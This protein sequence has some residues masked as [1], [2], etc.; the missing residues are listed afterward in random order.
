MPNPQVF[1]DVEIGGSAAGR[2]VFELRADVAP[3]TAENFRLLCTGEKGTG[4][5][6]KTL[7]YKG[8]IFHR[9]IPNFMCQGGD[10][11]SGDG[12]GGES[13]YGR[14]FEDENFTLKHDGPGVLS[15]ANA[16][17][18]TNGSQFFLCTVACPWLDGKHV[19]FGRLIE[20][21]GVMKR[22]EACGSRSGKT[23]KP[24]VI[25]DCGQISNNLEYIRKLQEERKELEALRQD[26]I[27]LDA[28]KGSLTR[29]Q[30][31]RE[32]A[33]KKQEASRWKFRAKT[34]QDE[35]LELDSQAT[36]TSLAATDGASCPPSSSD[37]GN[38]DDAEENGG[39][40]ATV[41][42]VDPDNIEGANPLAGLSGR[43]RK[44][45]ELRSR[46]QECR[47][48]NQHAVIAETKRRQVPN[49]ENSVSK[50]KWFEERKKR[51]AAELERLGLPPDAVHRIESA[52]V[53]QAKH[54]KQKEKPTPFG[55][56][57]FNQKTLYKAYEKRA[58]QVP[59]TLEDYEEEKKRNPD[60]YG[61]ASGLEYGRTPDVPEEN[62]DKMVGELNEAQRRRQ[63]F[64]RRRRH[65]EDKDIDYINDRN[66][67]F[68]KKIERAFGKFTQEIRAN[69]ERGTALPD[70]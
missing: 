66:A 1:F 11:T 49:A 32:Q 61:D 23:L 33:E 16:G 70:H 43:K 45:Y 35:L 18:N 55:W 3:K 14:T 34:A 8:S 22:I 69:L 4:Q 20:G 37:N 26:P 6:G 64:S 60:F 29:L 2:I 12:T 46:L 40:P 10:F 28:D 41:R 24:V 63:Q 21:N 67:H 56:D 38:K 31:A 5:G 9:V 51:Q 47:K 25:S 30:A 48:A 13:I 17:P 50:R 58:E 59:Y 42:E 15:M 19:V 62:V 68:N 57:A 36:S 27:G 7:H 65:Y 54:E 53:A 52:E 39:E 44:L